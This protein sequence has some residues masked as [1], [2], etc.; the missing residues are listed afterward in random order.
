MIAL[1]IISLLGVLAMLSEILYFKKFLPVLTLL[2]LAGAVLAG[3]YE[4]Q[5][6]LVIEIFHSM[7]VMNHFALAFSTSMIVIT[8]LW[9]LLAQGALSK[10][11]AETDKYALILFSLAGG[12]IMSGF[13]NL[14]MLFLGIEILSIPL[15][16]LAGSNKTSLNSNESAFKYFLM[17]AFAS[18]FLL[19]G[20]TLIYGAT[21]SFHLDAIAQ[22]VQQHKG[23]L[24]SFFYAGIVLIIAGLGFKIAA[25]PFHFW[26]PDVYQGAPNLITAFMSTIVKTAAFAAFYR[27]FNTCFA[28]VSGS[29]EH[30][31]WIMAVITLLLGNISAIYQESFKRLLAFSSVSHAGYLLLGIIALNTHSAGALFM[32]TLAYS[33]ASIS[34]FTVLQQIDALKGNDLISSFNGLAKRNR[35]LAF[36][37]TVSMLSLAGIPP[38]GGFIAKFYLFTTAFDNGYVGLVIMAIIASL[39]GV[40]YYF[41]LI[42]AAYFKHAEDDSAIHLSSAHRLLVIA[43][44][45]ITLAIGLFPGFIL[46]LF[47]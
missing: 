25:V 31:L 7:M 3:F 17:G 35:L 46:E 6:P 41:R 14:V 43:C 19:F 20:F 23:D 30:L 37:L 2:G 16:V 33:V 36:G 8:F 13:G 42:I 40:Y 39:I 9:F 28:G 38:T 4:W 15:Y 18:S 12:I 22:A 21:G 45:I 32:Y 1:V 24:P 34:A 5:H 10:D 11:V 29:W 47:S 44:I 26:A 27:L